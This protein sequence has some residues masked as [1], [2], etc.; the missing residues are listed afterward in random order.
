MVDMAPILQTRAVDGGHPNIDVTGVAYLVLS[1]VYTLIVSAELY[2]LY[3]I[4]YLYYPISLLLPNIL[5]YRLFYP[6][7]ISTLIYR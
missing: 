1:A 2:F 7:F 3:I 4:I 5:L 6:Y